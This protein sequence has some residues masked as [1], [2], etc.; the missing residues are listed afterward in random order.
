M[1]KGYNNIGSIEALSQLQAPRLKNLHLSFNEIKEARTLR[2]CHF[3]FLEKLSLM[4]TK[5]IDL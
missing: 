2:K 4:A 3:P 1:L 5:I